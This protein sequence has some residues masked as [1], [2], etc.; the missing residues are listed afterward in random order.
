[1]TAGALG[2]L[3]AGV[4]SVAADGCFCES[5]GGVGGR[6]VAEHVSLGGVGRAASISVVRVVAHRFGWWRRAA[7]D[8]VVPPCCNSKADIKGNPSPPILAMLDCLYAMN[9]W[10]NTGGSMAL[11][12]MLGIA[13]RQFPAGT[14]GGQREGAP[15]LVLFPARASTA[16]Q[17][18]SR[19]EAVRTKGTAHHPSRNGARLAGAM[20]TM[21]AGSDGSDESV[22]SDGMGGRRRRACEVGWCGPC[23]IGLG[24]ADC[25][26]S[27]WVVPSFR[28]FGPTRTS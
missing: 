19:L 14:G 24:G 26:A 12:V 23:C 13:D 25:A 22:G 1:M 18:R 2:P 5:P 28:P 8:W 20:R 7:S 16:H 27:G 10:K 9:A 21:L 4:L 3:W 6:D 17:R 15:H 11:P